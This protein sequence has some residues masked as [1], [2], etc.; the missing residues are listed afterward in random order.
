MGELVPFNGL[1]RATPC[2]AC[3]GEAAHD[4]GFLQASGCGL[5]RHRRLVLRGEAERAGLP[6]E[7]LPDGVSGT[8]P[9]PRS[10]AAEWSC[11]LLQRRAR[12]FLARTASPSIPLGRR[13]CESSASIAASTPV[14][15]ATTARTASAIGSSTPARRPR[16]Q[17]ASDGRRPRSAS[18]RPRSSAAGLPCARA[19]PKLVLREVRLVAVSRRSPRPDRP[20]RVSRRAPRASAKRVISASPRVISEARAFSPRPCSMVT[21]AAMAITFFSAPASSTPS[22]SSLG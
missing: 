20:I 11:G 21:P 9:R 2:R 5:R 16:R 12:P 4:M 6:G 7:I 10:S 13:Q 8:Q 18:R 15:P 14:S 22:R 19:N 17:A 1:E 3:P